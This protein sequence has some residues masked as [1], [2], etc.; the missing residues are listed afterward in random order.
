MKNEGLY[1]GRFEPNV[2][3]FHL[4]KYA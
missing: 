2:N 1:E 3:D 4:C